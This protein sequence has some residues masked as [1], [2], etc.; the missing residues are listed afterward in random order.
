MKKNISIIIGLV[1]ALSMTFVL[2]GCGSDEVTITAIGSTTVGPIAQTLADKYEE[3][4]DVLIDIQGGG[5]SVGVSK[6][7]EQACDIGMASRE[8]KD[9]E[10]GQGLIEHVIARDGIAVI[11]NNSNTVSELSLDQIKSIFKKEITNWNEVGGVDAP[12]VVCAREA[13]SGTRAAF[14]EIANIY[15][16]DADGNEIDL[17]DGDVISDSNGALKASVVGNENTI[18]FLSLGLLDEEVKGI[19]VEGVAPTVANVLTGEYSI[20][21]PLLLLTSGEEN[22]EANAFIDFILSEEGQDI[23]EEEKYIR[24]D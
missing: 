24:V 10:K 12:I 13:G 21:R 2:A 6:A 8:L 18:G 19:V 7:L 15:E 22:E 11:V 5:S 17:I 23:V 1:L 16:K 4:N 3:N 20:S 14:M 9:S